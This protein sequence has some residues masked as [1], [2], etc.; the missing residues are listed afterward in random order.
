MSADPLASGARC[1]AALNA[2]AARFGFSATPR[3]D[4]EL[5]LAHA[6]GIERST[7]LLDLDR[8]VPPAFADLAARRERQE[9]VAYITGTRGFWTLDLTVGPGALVPRADSETLIAAAVAHFAGRPPATLL[10]LGAGPGT[11]LLALLDEWRDARGLGVDRSAEALAWARINA[12]AFGRRA[13]FVQGDWTTA[14]T[15]PFDCIVA[16]PPYIATG[17]D[18][19]PEVAAFEPAEALFAGPDGLD[20]YRRLAPELRRLLAPG[21]AVLLEIGWTQAQAV[22]DL[23]RDRGFVVTEHCDL[24]GRPRVLSGVLPTT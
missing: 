1:A 17:E 22:G 9:P 15:G 8:P 12:T 23:L 3:L 5:L 19:P 13:A 16:N 24:G 2:A 10:D 21:G 7:L 18:L 11:L 6:L 14:I 4:A 20:D